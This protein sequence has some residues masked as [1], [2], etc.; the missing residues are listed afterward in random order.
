MQ[1]PT[2]YILAML[3]L[4]VDVHAMRGEDL[5][6]PLQKSEGEMPGLMVHRYLSGQVKQAIDRWKADY[7][8]RK[9]P[10]DIAAYQK[11]YHGAF[12]EAV[13]GL[14]ER[15]PLN[16]QIVGTIAKQGYRVEKIIFESQPKHYVT[17]LLFMPQATGLEP[18]TFG[19][20]GRLI[21]KS[22]LVAVQGLTALTRSIACT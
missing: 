3:L 4:L 15:T 9:T 11:R 21:A 5:D 6:V 20:V 18:V 22:E 8:Q 7:V 19:S 14:P 13:G 17:S 12:I 10:E 1:R 2:C 16:P